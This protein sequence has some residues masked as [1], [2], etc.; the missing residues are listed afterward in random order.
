M[1]KNQNLKN[2]VGNYFEKNAHLGRKH[3]FDTFI[4]LETVKSILNRWLA[5]LFNKKV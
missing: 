3:I 5:L 4:K 2:V 1:T